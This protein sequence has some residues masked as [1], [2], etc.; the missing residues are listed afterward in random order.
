VSARTDAAARVAV[1]REALLDLTRALVRLRTVNRP[2]EGLSEAP[3]AEFVAGW[4]RERGWSPLVEEVAPGRPNVICAIDGGGGPGRTLLFEGHT[5][6]VTEGDGSDWERD[7]FGAEVV[8]G[9][10][11]GRGAADMKGGLAAMLFAADSLARERPW[12]GRLVLAVLA[13]EEGMMLGAKGFVAAGH[14]RG[15]DAAIICEPE[16]GEL[17]LTQKGA[18]RARVVATGRMAHGAMPQHGLNPVPALA[19]FVV[20]MAALERQLQE[21]HGEDEHLGWPYVTPTVLR[22]GHPDQVNVIPAAGAVFLDVRTTPAIDHAE[23]IAHVTQIAV[24]VGERL[25]IE[26]SVDVIDD[27]PATSTPAEAPVA[28]ALAAAHEAIHGSRPPVGGVPGTTDGTI[29]WRDAGVPVVTY[30]PGDKWIAHQANEHVPVAELGDYA[31]VYAEA[32]RL[33]LRGDG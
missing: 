18:I 21:R 9:V 26:L 10:L 6:V 16:G 27:R 28:L 14:A 33:F 15:V 3:A 12:P 20:E 4:M 30:G 5:D 31:E 1:D 17:C 8:D 7:P 25:G 24:S 32:A 19:A 23:L 13:D 29:L 22:A 2:E 11:W